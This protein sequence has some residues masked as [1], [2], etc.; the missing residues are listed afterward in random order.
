MVMWPMTSRDLDRSGTWPQNVWGPLS[1]M[2]H[3]IWRPENVK[4]VNQIYLDAN[5]LKRQEI[6]DQFQWTTSRNWPMANR[7]VTQSMTSHDF[8]KRAPR[9]LY[10]KRDGIGQTPC[11]YEHYLVLKKFSTKFVNFT[12]WILKMPTEWILILIF[13]S[14]L[15]TE[16]IRTHFFTESQSQKHSRVTYQTRISVTRSENHQQQ[17]NI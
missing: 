12:A 14:L 8:V 9:R 5:I 10:R 4:I 15:L 13:S 3:N 11:S 16:Q 2:T 7:M 1:H 6:E 17:L